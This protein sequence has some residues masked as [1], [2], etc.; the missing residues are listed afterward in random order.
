MPMVMGLLLREAIVFFC[1]PVVSPW[2]VGWLLVS[3]G[4]RLLVGIGCIGCCFG[5]LFVNGGPTWCC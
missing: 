4:C 3:V 5:S 1:T 2:C